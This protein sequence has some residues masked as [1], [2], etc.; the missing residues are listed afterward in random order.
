MRGGSSNGCSFLVTD[1][2]GV[3]VIVLGVFL[4]Y[5]IKSYK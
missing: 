2:V 4:Y 3:V 5:V 1:L